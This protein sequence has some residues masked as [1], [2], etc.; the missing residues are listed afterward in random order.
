SLSTWMRD[1]LYFSLGGNRTGAVR[2]YANLIITMTLCGL[3]HGASWNYVVWGAYN[4]VL[5][6]FHRVYD[7]A[8]R[9][10][11]WADRIRAQPL[12]RLVAVC[13]TFYLFACGLVPVRSESWTGCW[14]ME[15]A[16]LGLP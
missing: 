8:L 1:Y 3:W 6:A 4:G 7:R 12:F 9:G 14:L 16:L 11:D 2:T 5:L 13:S 10:R 15:R